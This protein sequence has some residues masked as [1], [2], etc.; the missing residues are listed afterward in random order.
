[1]IKV[2]QDWVEIGEAN[3]SLGRLALP[4]HSSAEKNWDFYQLY[5]LMES[6]Q[7]ELKI[8]DLG[9]GGGDTLRLLG[10]MGFENLLG[11]DLSIRLQ[12]RLRQ[13]LGM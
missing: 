3:K 10:A 7:R 4:K 9:C 11:I 8:V 2:L 6:Q 12:D 5:Q 13:I 1:M